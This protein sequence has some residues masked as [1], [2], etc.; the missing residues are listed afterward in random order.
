[1]KK[2]LK[3]MCLV[4]VLFSLTACKEKR[5]LTVKE[6]NDILSDKGFFVNDLSSQME[7]KQI[8]VVNVANNGKYQIEYYVFV[9]EEAAK[10]A[11]NRN[12]KSF[13][14]MNK[15]RGKKTN[16]DNYDKYTQKLSDT[17]NSLTRIGKTLVYA[18]I[19]IEYKNDFNK[20]LKALNY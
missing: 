13:E 6:M 8:K 5:E 1:M 12:I 16:K 4:L 18:S 14:D 20:V 19:N 11:F 17:Y 2:F 7:D 9:T 10:E 3:F 15:T